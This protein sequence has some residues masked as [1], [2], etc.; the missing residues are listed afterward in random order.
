MACGFKNFAVSQAAKIENPTPA[1]FSFGLDVKANCSISPSK[2]LLTQF[3]YLSCMS[4]TIIDEFVESAKRLQESIRVRDRDSAQG[5]YKELYGIYSRLAASSVAD[6]HK[7]VAYEQLTKFYD[8]LSTMKPRV[9]RLQRDW[10]AGKDL[11]VIGALLVVFI[12]VLV[13]KPSIVGLVT[14]DVRTIEINTGFNEDVAYELALPGP[15]KSLALT[16]T[17]SGGGTAVVI[18]SSNGQDV[19]VFDSKKNA[20][21]GTFAFKEVCGD[22]CALSGFGKKVTLHIDVDSASLFLAQATVG[23]DASRNKAPVWQGFA[24]DFPVGRSEPVDID[25]RQSFFD[26]DGDELVFLSTADEGLDVIVSGS[27]VTIDA[28]RASVGEHL[29]TF[30]ASDLLAVTKQPV[31][32]RVQAR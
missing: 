17:V 15:P 13:F 19:V 24:T 9:E 6:V 25:L 4:P 32:I 3:L 21:P 29:V 20:L 7:E 22:A 18:A 28:S 14:A 23:I 2:H 5:R 26:P 30:I 27:L 31:T 10:L 16:G 8:G 12:V 1:V 11:A